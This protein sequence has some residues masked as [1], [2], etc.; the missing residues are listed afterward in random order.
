[1][2]DNRLYLNRVVETTANILLTSE[3]FSPGDYYD[4]IRHEYRVQGVRY[5]YSSV[6]L[7]DFA[8]MVLREMKEQGRRNNVSSRVSSRQSN[9]VVG[10]GKPLMKNKAVKEVVNWLSQVM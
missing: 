7:A 3:E 9:K 6:T 5:S 2:S 8:L 10:R 4:S 1:M